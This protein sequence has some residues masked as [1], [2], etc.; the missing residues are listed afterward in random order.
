MNKPHPELESV[1]SPPPGEPARVLVIDDDEVDRELVRRCLARSGL[2]V[3]LLEEDDPIAAL[4]RVRRSPVEV[5]LLDYQFP[6]HDGLVVLRGLRELDVFVPAIVL[7]GHEDTALAV[8]LMKNGAVDYIAKGALTPQ[9]LG[10]SIRHALRLRASELATRAAQEALRASEE[11]S[12]RILESSHDGIVVLDLEGR[13]LSISPGGLRMLGAAE[14]GQLRG[15]PWVDLWSSAHRQ[16]VA[17]ALATARAGKVGRVVGLGPALDGASMWWDVIVSPVLAASGKPER[18]VATARDVTEQRRQAEFEQQLI[19][20]VSHDLRNPLSAMLTGAWLLAESLPPDSPLA[21]VVQRIVRSGER[22]TRLIRDLLDFTQVR[23]SGRLPIDP[24]PVEIHEVCR[25]V[26]EEM[27]LNHPDRVILHQP[28]GDG[29][30]RWDPDRLAQAVGNLVHNA[31][32]YGLSGAPVT[33]RSV[34]RGARAQVLVHNEGPPI[35]PESI[36]SLFQPFRRGEQ[37]HDRE[38]SI[39]LGLFIVREIVDAHGGN[40]AVH[41]AVGEGTTFHIDLPRL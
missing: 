41:S 40:V 13:M 32:S 25:Q 24:R 17:E 31:L 28:E 6:R 38:R 9:R 34:G 23:A 39:G 5:V 21:D 27:A 8:E 14:P 3:T 36:P 18:L 35:P 4:A 11:F 10:Q 37:R 2:E 20:I 7:T 26:V 30:G 16:E 29:E 1:S 12:R 33:V 22:A 19:G 15:R